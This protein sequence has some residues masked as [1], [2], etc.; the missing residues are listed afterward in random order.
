MAIPRIHRRHRQ[1]RLS[2]LHTAVRLYAYIFILFPVSF[3][4]AEAISLSREEEK[5]LKRFHYFAV[6]EPRSK[7]KK[8]WFMEWHLF[9]YIFDLAK[10]LA[11]QSLKE[12]E[13]NRII[14]D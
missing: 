2:P 7:K 8:K 12:D 14:P 13:M 6:L 3:K 11:L 1:R 5:T 10:R 4:H 9:F